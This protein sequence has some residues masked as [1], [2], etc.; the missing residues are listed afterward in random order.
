MSTLPYDFY[1]GSAVVY[2]DELHILGGSYYSNVHYGTNH[3]AYDGIKWSNTTTL[4]YDFYGGAAVAFGDEIHII[5]GAS[6]P[7]DSKKHYS[8]KYDTRHIATVLPKGIHILLSD[9]ENITYVS[10]N[11]TKIS[12]T[13]AEV[14]ETGY[15]EILTKYLNPSKVR[16]FLT[17]Y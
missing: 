5:G 9:N 8:V 17:F 11:T 3:Y 15:V 4:P 14:K 13:I 16:K 2:N 1:N 10:G 6:D 12:E 7:S